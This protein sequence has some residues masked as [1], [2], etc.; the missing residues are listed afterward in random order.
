MK[1][2]KFIVALSLL[3]LTI[4]GCNAIGSPTPP[5][6]P[7]SVQLNW[8]HYGFFG[9]LYA[10]D[11][12]GNFAQEGLAVTFIEGG[13]TV[14]YITPV[15]DGTAQFGI[16]N[17]DTLIQARAQGI[18]VRAI[19]TILQRSP[20]AFG[21]LVDSGITRP[22]D[23]VGHTI[24]VTPQIA[25]VFHVM[26]ARLG[27]SPDQYT[28][29]VLPS[30]IEAFTSG[31][32]DVWSMYTNSFAIIVEK[33]GYKLNYIYPDDYGIH[34]YA[35]SL[36]T[37]DDLIAKAPDLVPRFVRAALSGYTFAVENPDKI[38][39]MA[40]N[41]NVQLDISI[42]NDQMTASIPLIN[43]GED[44]I[45]WMKPE[46]WTGMEA[47]LREQGVITQPLDVTEVY[48]MQFLKTIYEGK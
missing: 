10:A 9:G 11:Q 22:Q 46:I 14:D 29:I 45:G 31:Q 37:S 18:P 13:P 32:A 12:N 17:A 43:T 3:T 34:F 23:F 28:E 48:T 7:I 1:I 38:G 26:M 42:C 24:Q 25:P 40:V 36:F 35:E 19:A 47:T 41:Y 8:L 44:Y 27:I 39:L 16:A 21:V 6:I 4:A 33:A 2:Y 5:P 20:L 30:T 15:L